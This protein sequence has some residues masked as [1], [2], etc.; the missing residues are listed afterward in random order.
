[1]PGAIRPAA[2]CRSLFSAWRS[3]PRGLPKL[4]GPG[5]ATGGR[6]PQPRFAVGAPESGGTWSESGGRWRE[7]ASGDMDERSYGVGFLSC[8]VLLSGGHP[9]PQR[10][11]VS[12][13]SC[14]KRKGRKKEADAAVLSSPNIQARLLQPG[15]SKSVAF[16]NNE[17]PNTVRV[18]AGMDL[19]DQI[20][21]I[22][23]S[24]CLVKVDESRYSPRA[25][26]GAHRRNSWGEGIYC[27]SC[28]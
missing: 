20:L 11:L 16:V 25:R 8:K 13:V 7:A 15:R 26:R 24:L 4:Q 10:A 17:K 28:A 5:W 21:K 9:Q 3:R 6:R 23:C 27:C 18:L 22:S 19:V 12:I 14:F 2:Q 1:M